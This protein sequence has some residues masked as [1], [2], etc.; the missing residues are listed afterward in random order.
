MYFRILD[1]AGPV[2]LLLVTLLIPVVA[3]G[4]G[5][6]VLGERMGPHH[7]AGLG[8]IA[9]GLVLIDGRLLQRRP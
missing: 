4:L 2:N 6:A 5:I 8:L 1:I 3:I 7:G 9:L